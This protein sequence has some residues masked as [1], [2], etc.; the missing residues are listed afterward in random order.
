[1]KKIPLKSG[2]EF[3]AFTGW[4]RFYNW[5]TKQLK[6]IKRKYRKRFRQDEKKL[7]DKEL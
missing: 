2:D 3:D 6:K 1:M 7:I 4:R 5:K